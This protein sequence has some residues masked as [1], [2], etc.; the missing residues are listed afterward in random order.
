M[1]LFQSAADRR[2]FLAWTATGLGGW[3]GLGS[4][5]IPNA[6]G[7][8]AVDGWW[9]TPGLFA[10]ELARTPKQTEGPFYPDHLPLD[11]DN[12]LL[13]INDQLT[14]AVGELTHLSGRVLSS[15]GEPLRNVVVEIWQVDHYG[16]YLHSKS[17]GAK[18][19]D[20]NFQGYGRFTTGTTGE[21]YFR[22]VK[23]VVY[24]GRQAPHIHFKISRG[25][26]ELLTTQCYIAGH[27]GNARDGI[28]RGLG[29]DKQKALVSV[30]FE[31]IPESKLGEIAARFDLVLGATP[32]D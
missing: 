6:S 15:S 1:S 5:L 2:R 24:P 23:P 31:P 18:R 10:E 14:P 11:T 4:G 17:D 20:Q 22:T 26:R 19:R 21:Y 13:I 16:V 12:D 27:P 28:Y 7:R 3:A 9:T 29:D 25:D 32:E 8:A 30:N